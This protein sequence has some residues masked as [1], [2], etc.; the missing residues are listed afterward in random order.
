MPFQVTMTTEADGRSRDARRGLQPRAGAPRAR[1]AGS[2]RGLGRGLRISSRRGSSSSALSRARSGRERADVVGE[3]RGAVGAG[4][5]QARQRAFGRAPAAAEAELLAGQAR[6]RRRGAQRLDGDPRQLDAEAI[7]G[8]A[9]EGGE[10]PVAAGEE[11]VRSA[12]SSGHAERAAAGWRRRPPGR[13]AR[14]RSRGR[15]ILEQADAPPDAAIEAAGVVERRLRGW[16][17]RASAARSTDAPAGRR[18]RRARATRSAPAG[19]RRPGQRRR[20][21][22]RS[23]SPGR[24]PPAAA[25]ARSASTPSA[26]PRL[27]HDD[28]VAACAA[29]G[30]ADRGRGAARRVA[31]LRAPRSPR[32]PGRPSAM[33][34]ASASRTGA[35]GQTA[36]ARMKETVTIDPRDGAPSCETR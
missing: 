20:R 34:A 24:V 33:R 11:R 32:R 2:R 15:Q 21:P 22:G 10:D 13:P 27:E 30:V 14:S 35:S 29:D 17:T 18:R 16:P 6:R 1:A 9:A 12:G 28:D 4:P 5:Q 7:R 36:P 19:R 3:I 26:R 25:S 8:Q 23:R 31:R